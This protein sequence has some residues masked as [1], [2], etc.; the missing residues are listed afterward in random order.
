MTALQYVIVA[1]AAYRLTR[2]FVKDSLIGFGPD[3][4]SAISQR[5]DQ[6]AYDEEGTDRS[7]WRGKA[8]DL[9][10][11]TWC[12]G[13]WISAATYTVAAISLREWSGQPLLWHGIAIF[14]V[15]GA[16]GLLSSRL[17]A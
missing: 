13:F 8:G 4:G 2:F 15:A 11:C 3:S 5:I 16:Q 9:L 12:L 14:G 7:F 10:T 1:L 17:A 6:F